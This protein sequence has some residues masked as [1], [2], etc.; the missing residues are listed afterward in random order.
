MP[1]QCQVMLDG[2]LGLDLFDSS[3]RL[4]RRSQLIWVLSRVESMG[5]HDVSWVN[6]QKRGGISRGKGQGC[7]VPSRKNGVSWRLLRWP[8]D[9]PRSILQDNV[10]VALQVSSYRN[11]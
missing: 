9:G 11:E 3:S 4:S 10:A 2:R 8:V 1:P 6:N 7:D 5:V